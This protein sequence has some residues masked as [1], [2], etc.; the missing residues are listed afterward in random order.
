MNKKRVEYATLRQRIY[1]LLI[2]L[3]LM[4][5]PIYLVTVVVWDFA[6]IISEKNFPEIYNEMQRS[7][8]SPTP[9]IL[10]ELSIIYYIQTIAAFLLIVL[11]FSISEVKMDGQS[12][13][14][15]ITNIKVISENSR[16]YNFKTALT[17]NFL[18]IFDFPFGFLLILKSKKRQRPGDIFTK[19]VVIV[20]K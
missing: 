2:D 8:T 9:Y 11:Y 18:R 13:G 6:L 7:M 20:D 19:T 5:L 1:A 3:F 15:I 17:R 12:V 4:M 10:P 16:R 14:K